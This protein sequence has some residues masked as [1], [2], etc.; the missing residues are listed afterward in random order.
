MHIKGL[1]KIY[2]AFL[3]PA[4]L[5]FAAALWARHDWNP[6]IVVGQDR[7][8]VSAVLFILSAIS[9]G[10]APLLYRIIFAF[11][12]RHRSSVSSG[13]LYR[14]ERNLI[15]IIMATPYLALCAYVM[16]VPQFHFTGILLMTLYAVYY[17]YPG[18]NRIRADCKIYRVLPTVIADIPDPKALP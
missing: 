4:L 3:V 7:I 5:G 15:V 11:W 6:V 8:F 17:Y 1:L 9:A 2:M 13:E 10:A 12:N 18:H 16:Q 14:F